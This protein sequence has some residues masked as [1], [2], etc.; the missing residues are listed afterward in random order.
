MRV[1]SCCSI[2]LHF[3]LPHA[4]SF[5]KCCCSPL[6]KGC[7]YLEEQGKKG[8]IASEVK[9]IHTH[10]PQHHRSKRIWFKT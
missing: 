6:K 8:T 9:D 1:I 2:F 10:Y 4:G 7:I 5:L 3:P